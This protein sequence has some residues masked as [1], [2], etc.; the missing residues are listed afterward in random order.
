[1]FRV[2]LRLRR[3]SC[4]ARWLALATTRSVGTL[5]WCRYPSFNSLT[6]GFVSEQ[7]EDTFDDDDAIGGVGAGAGSGA[8]GGAGAGA[9]AGEFG[10]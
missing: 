8:G 2:C 4:H 9:G 5:P 1:M 6:I 3:R 7:A 10:L